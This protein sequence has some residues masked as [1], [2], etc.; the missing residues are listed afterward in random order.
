MCIRDS[1]S[2][3]EEVKWKAQRRSQ[4]RTATN[5]SADRYQKKKRCSLIYALTITASKPKLEN[6]E[7]GASHC[8][9]PVVMKNV[10]HSSTWLGFKKKFL[11]LYVWS[12]ALYGRESWTTGKPEG[13]ILETL[14]MWC[15]R[16]MLKI[17]W[18]D[19]VTNERV[20]E[21]IGERSGR[22]R[23]GRSGQI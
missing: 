5:H 4:W 22:N 20:E 19:K 11:K 21:I 17:K 12:V 13:R 2:S 1:C 7:G 9:T 6:K 18:V 15:R 16:T 23:I 14:E 8:L 10:A 3:Y